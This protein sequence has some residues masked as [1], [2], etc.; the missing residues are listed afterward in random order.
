MDTSIESNGLRGVVGVG[1]WG[2]FKIVRSSIVDHPA[3]GVLVFGVLRVRDSVVAGNGTS[4][5]LCLMGDPDPTPCVDLS[6][7]KKFRIETT[8]CG[9]S[10]QSPPSAPTGPSVDQNPSNWSTAAP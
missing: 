4:L 8:E 10:Y 5:G 2:N 1:T 3:D 6:V 7:G 9:S